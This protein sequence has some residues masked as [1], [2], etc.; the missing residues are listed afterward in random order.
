MDLQ[1]NKDNTVKLPTAI[2]NSEVAIDV[3][4]VR[5]VVKKLLSAE[6]VIENLTPRIFKTF[7]EVIHS[8]NVEEFLKLQKA[9]CNAS[10]FK[11]VSQLA[12]ASGT[13]TIQTMI[14]TLKRYTKEFTGK[15]ESFGEIQKELKAVAQAK[16]STPANGKDGKT[17]DSTVESGTESEVPS[18]IPSSIV[19]P[20]IIEFINKA[21][22]LSVEQQKEIGKVLA[23]INS[24]I[25]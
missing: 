15:P 11:N 20:H 23:Q 9:F 1:I 18:A 19:D 14:S 12:E 8:H 16:N 5:E 21:P 25:K 24:Q 4:E 13:K 10:G 22:R 7:R 3:K 6:L 17:P 2:N